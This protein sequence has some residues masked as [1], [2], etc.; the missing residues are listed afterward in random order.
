MSVQFS[1]ASSTTRSL[2][3]VAGSVASGFSFLGH[4]DPRLSVFVLS[5]WRREERQPHPPAGTR[6]GAPAVTTDDNNAVKKI[7]NKGSK[8]LS[9]EQNIERCGFG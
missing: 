8:T 9:D 5:G 7:E 4:F 6:T 2:R 3:S 1:S